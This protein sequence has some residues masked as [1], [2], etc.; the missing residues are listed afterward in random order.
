MRKFLVLIV[1]LSAAFF[2]C[3]TPEENPMLTDFNTPFDAPPFDRIDNEHFL[4]AYEQ[5][6]EQHKAE[7]ADIVNNNAVPDFENTIVAYDNAGE[8][9]GRVSR[10]F[11]GL[12]SANTNDRMQE[13]AKETTPMLSAHRNEIRFNEQLFARIKT[14]YDKRDELGLDPEQMR[15]VEKIYEDFARNGAALPEQERNRL[16][17]INERISMVSLQLGQNLLAENNGFKLVIEDETDLAGLPENVIS[18][19]AEE[20]KAA[21]HEGKWVFTLAKPSWIPFLQFSERRDLREKIYT[22]YINRGNN[23]NEHDNKELFIELMLLRQQMSELLGYDNYAEYF[24]SIQMAENPQNVYDF[25]YQVWEPSL[26]RAKSERDEMQSIVNREGKNFDLQSWDWWYYAEIVREEK[27]NLNEDDLKPYFSLDNVRNGIFLLSEKLFGLTFEKRPE[28]PVYHEEVE[29]FEVFDRDGSHLGILYID[30]HPR[31]GKRSG[32]WC[33]TY[34]NGTYE[35]GKKIA[36]IVTIVMN[37]TRPTGDQPALLSWDEAT[38]YFHEFGHALHNLFADGHYKRTSRSV[39][40]DF[41]ELPSQI[42][43]NWAGEPKLLKEYA[44]HFQTGQPIP[45]ELIEKLDNSKYFNQGF[46]NTEYLAAAILDMDWHTSEISSNT[47]VIAFEEASMDR[48]GLI[49]EIVPRYRTTNF[50]HI[51][52]SGYAAGYY[53]YRWAGVLDA[54]AFY[55]FKE[56]GDLFNRE[57]AEKFRKYI[58]AENALWEGMDAYVKFRGQEPSIDPFLERSGL[59]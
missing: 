36:P 58:L 15:V 46:A 48:I 44:L 45:D 32:A 10:I 2:G 4:P 30:P 1:A 8:L 24:T 19:A 57:L 11:G 31:P 5:A 22:A 39:P 59:K 55:A 29:A 56:S 38:T 42:M 37:F 18:A 13:I 23:D 26:A 6:I 17:A 25:L 21:G 54:D 28:V 7:I 20:A 50:G 49:D 34:R 33:G 16:K 12:N 3:S 51:F 47:D 53:V 43:E 35:D 41:V 9:L 52:G 14:V 40:R 27:Y